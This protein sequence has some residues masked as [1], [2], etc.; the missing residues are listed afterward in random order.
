M[1]WQSRGVGGRGGG[2]GGMKEQPCRKRRRRLRCVSVP[3][4]GKEQS[5][6]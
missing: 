5:N 6:I 4:A 1:K 3:P 2:G